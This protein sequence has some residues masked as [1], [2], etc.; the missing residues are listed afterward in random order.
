MATLSDYAALAAFVYN[1]ERGNR[2][3]TNKLA[4]PVEWEQLRAAIGFPA[5][6]SYDDNFFS[7]TAGAF[8]NQSTGEIVISYKG[9]D[10]LVEFSG[11]AWNTVG[12][13]LTDLSA[14]VGGFVSPPSSCRRL[15]TTKK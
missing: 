2:G 4:L 6:T 15:R 10:F 1:N 14:G 12:D 13:I 7:F 5:Q 8:V 11:R 9:T 3:A